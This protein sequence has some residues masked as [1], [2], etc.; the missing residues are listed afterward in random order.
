MTRNMWFSWF[1]GPYTKTLEFSRRFQEPEGRPIMSFNPWVL[2]RTS[3]TQ[4]SNYCYHCYTYHERRIE[5]RLQH[6]DSAHTTNYVDLFVV[7]ELRLGVN[8]LLR[9]TD[10]PDIDRN[11]AGLPRPSLLCAYCDVLPW[12]APGHCQ[13]HLLRRKLLGSGYVQPLSRHRRP[14]RWVFSTA[15][16]A[17]HVFFRPACLSTDW[18]VGKKMPVYGYR[19]IYMC[20]YVVW[21]TDLRSNG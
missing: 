18:S 11:W 19:Y 8:V 10:R 17:Y 2:Q 16:C 20:V 1:R 21:I 14:R 7:F 12:L 5:W 6:L 4:L 9:C 15:H 13:W 3:S